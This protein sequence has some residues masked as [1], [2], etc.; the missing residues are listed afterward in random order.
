[1]EHELLRR[2]REHGAPLVDE[3]GATFVW[4][5]RTPPQLIGDFN[6]W[7]EGQ[8]E[9]EGADNAP[10]S[11]VTLGE[12]EPGLWAYTLLLPQ[13]AYMEYAFIVHGKRALDPLNPH[14]AP[15]GVGDYNNTFYM[16]GAAATPL[17]R[18]ERGGSRGTLT[19]HALTGSEVIVGT[20]RSVHLYQPP[21]TKPG[22]Y[23]LLVVLDG[24]D[25]LRRA[26]LPVIVDNLIAQGRIPPLAL[27]LVASSA[28]ARFVEYACSDATVGFLT[29]VVVPFAREHLSVQSGVGA[30]GIMGASMGGVMALYAAQ[31]APDVFGRV[32]SQSGAFNIAEHDLVVFDLLRHMPRSALRIWM[33]V[34]RYE[35]LLACNRRMHDLLRS[36]GYAVTYRE[37][38]G[39][40][41]YPAWRDDLWRGLEVLYGA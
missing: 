25:Y 31:R 27:A 2:A 32:L 14:R 12:V 19:R 5:G 1:M 21:A 3:T 13:D 35:G 37:Y 17:A 20:W 24:Q 10:S 11:P 7:G 18:R 40:H 15:N 38:N 28:S 33:D 4:R 36:K 6:N 22:P 8:G 9:A 29:E 34:G 26:R 41:N 39:G 23:P 16:P 30:C